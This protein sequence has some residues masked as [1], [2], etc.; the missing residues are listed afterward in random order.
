M[1]TT[2]KVNCHRSKHTSNS[3]IDIYPKVKHYYLKMFTE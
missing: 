1:K 2:T 3:Y